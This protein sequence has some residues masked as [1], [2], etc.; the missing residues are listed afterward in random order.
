MDAPDWKAGLRAGATATFDALA[1]HPL[2]VPLFAATVPSGPNAT[3]MRERSIG[4][5]LE[6]G[7]APELAAHTYTSVGHLTIGFGLQ[8]L[9]APT[10]S[11][12]RR[13]LPPAT[14]RVAEHL[15]SSLREEFQ[16]GLQMMI[17]GVAASQPRDGTAL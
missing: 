16:F 12:A 7:F 13:H 9:Y 6:H 14:A 3:A 10:Q 8:L 4:Q 2:A 5:L 15:D 1:R 17:Q 11:L